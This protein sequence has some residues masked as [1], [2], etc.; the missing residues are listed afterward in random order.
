MNCPSCGK[1]MERGKIITSYSCGLFFLPPDGDIDAIILTKKY[2]ILRTRGEHS[3]WLINSLRDQII[4]QDSN[5]RLIT[6]K[7]ERILAVNLQMSVDSC[8]NPL[9]TSLFVAGST[10]NL[11]RKIQIFNIFQFKSSL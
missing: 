11:T 3:V 5:I 8:D 1:E 10:I 6:A 2:S 4:N 9:S 7:N